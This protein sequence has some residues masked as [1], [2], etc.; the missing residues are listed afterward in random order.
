MGLFDRLSKKK[1]KEK[2][3][4]KIQISDK[5]KNKHENVSVAKSTGSDIGFYFFNSDL[6]SQHHDN[7]ARYAFKTTLQSLSPHNLAY[8]SVTKTG[9]FQFIH[10]D[11][12][13]DKLLDDLARN[14]TD[15]GSINMIDNT[16]NKSLKEHRDVQS[17]FI[18]YCIGVWTD[19]NQALPMIHEGL[20]QQDTCGYLG[21]I[22]LGH[23]Y[24]VED[25]LFNF[26]RQLTLSINILITKGEYVA[27]SQTVLYQGELKELGFL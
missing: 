27:D 12:L 18:V 16:M 22:R 3:I 23:P 9:V 4:R 15:K 1:K 11:L 19:I 5:S 20:M 2:S 21:Y 25:L 14:V 8:R 24:S 13:D 7:Y 26:S 10:G 6:I 17:G